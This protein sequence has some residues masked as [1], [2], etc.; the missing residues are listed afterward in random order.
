MSKVSEEDELNF[1]KQDIIRGLASQGYIIDSETR[2]QIE[3]LPKSKIDLLGASM[4]AGYSVR[5]LVERFETEILP[6]SPEL[7]ARLTVLKAIK[8]MKESGINVSESQAK[9]IVDKLSPALAELDPEYLKVSSDVIA[10]QIQEE[11]LDKSVVT[12]SMLGGLYIRERNL[13]KIA[14]GLES[15]LDKSDQFQ[16]LKI[17]NAL[18]SLPAEQ[19]LDGFSKLLVERAGATKYDLNSMNPEDIARMRREDRARFDE[20]VFDRE[21]STVAIFVQGPDDV[22]DKV[23][24]KL[25]SDSGVKLGPDQQKGLRRTLREK[26]EPALSKLEPEYLQ[27]NGDKIASEIQKELYKDRSIAYRLGLTSFSVSDKSLD[28]IS[29]GINANHQPKSD[30]LESMIVKNGLD[31]FKGGKGKVELEG[32][33]TALAVEKAKE[34]ALKQD[35][36]T[37]KMTPEIVLQMRKEDPKMFDEIVLEKPKKEKIAVQGIVSKRTMADKVKESRAEGNDVLRR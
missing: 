34:D 1:K 7:M 19:A 24:S 25:I 31:Q 35:F 21:E 17:S 37:N 22:I 36:V 5:G 18:Y 13:D 6:E 14:I 27:A 12:S 33:L 16:L 4:E 23:I 11:V 2:K 29:K 8:S 20:I 28:N 26:V 10:K 15:H 9:M 3:G 30:D 32:R